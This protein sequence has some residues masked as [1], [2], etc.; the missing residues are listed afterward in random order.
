MHTGVEAMKPKTEATSFGSITID[1]QKFDHDIIIRLDGT[2]RKRKKKLSKKFYGTSHRISRE[3]AE[4]IYEDG[5]QKLVVGTGQYDRVRLSEE[6]QEY[7][8]GQG[9]KLLTVATPEAVRLWNDE[10]GALI[11]LF[12]VTC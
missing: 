5:A 3:E 6:A 7:F 11:G 8:D 1:S 4:F 10:E 12:H 2:I 9:L